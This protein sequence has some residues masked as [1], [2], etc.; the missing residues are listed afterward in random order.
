[1]NKD[2]RKNREALIRHFYISPN[3]MGG[4]NGSRECL[5]A[6]QRIA[7]AFGFD[8]NYRKLKHERDP[9]LLPLI[10]FSELDWLQVEQFYEGWDQFKKGGPK[11]LHQVADWLQTLPGW[12]R[13]LW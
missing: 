1:M 2:I 3:T 5:C 13:V 10:D 8:T 4:S 9:D 12:P 7:E 6:R 11:T